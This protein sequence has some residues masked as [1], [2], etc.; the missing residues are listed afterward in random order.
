MIWNYIIFFFHI[1]YEKHD[2]NCRNVE[3]IKMTKYIYKTWSKIQEETVQINHQTV[4][5]KGYRFCNLG[6]VLR[7][8][9]EYLNKNFLLR[10]GKLCACFFHFQG[11]KLKVCTMVFCSDLLW[12][13]IVLVIEKNFWNSRLKAEFANFLISQEQ[14]IQTVKGQSNLW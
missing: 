5:V 9:Y 8:F 11:D 3:H 14:F 2:T 13:K 12:E 4:A 7:K 6:T 1:L 10:K